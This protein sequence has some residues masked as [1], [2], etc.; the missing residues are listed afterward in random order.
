M[1]RAVLAMAGAALAG[2]LVVAL[3]TAAAPAHG[4][5][6]VTTPAIHAGV[7][8]SVQLV[9][10][11]A[12]NAYRTTVY[13]PAGY[14][15]PGGFGAV[16]NNVGK[17]HVDVVESDGSRVTLD[18]QLSVLNRTQVPAGTC[19][20][21]TRTHAAVW[22]L[23]AHESGGTGTI[24][25]PIYVDTT[26]TNRSLK[27][28]TPYS[29]QWCAGA[30]GQNV[31][32]VELDLVRMFVNPQRRGMH[33]WR[34]VYEPAASDGKTILSSSGV[35]VASAVPISPQVTLNGSRAA[36]SSSRATLAGTV[37]V[38]KQTLG[39]VRVQL[40]VG[41]SRRV[42]LERPAATVRTRADGSY[43]A[44]VKLTGDG[45]WYVRA[46]AST[47]F[48]DITPGGGCSSSQAFAPKGC[49][50]ATLA[51]FTVLSTPVGRI[52]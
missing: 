28:A 45:P 41:H 48:R 30:T 14:R 18:G 49:V 29:L 37:T 15:A 40:F 31:R 50:D 6:I 22:M 16:G 44:S 17:A 23:Q 27:A 1:K 32:E 11:P 7:A 24:T 46:K 51:P 33:I 13:V 36:V 19:A 9:A 43:T 39:N 3:A 25:F 2:V 42:A 21:S 52:G 10:I 35:S 38:A 4:R 34:A 8:T 47:P 12:P 26:T 20:S 5:L